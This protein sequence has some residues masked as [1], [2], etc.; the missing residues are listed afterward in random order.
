[1][2][3]L[4][5]R[6]RSAASVRCRIA[7]TSRTAK[8]ERFFDRGAHPP[9]PMLPYQTQHLDHL[10]CAALLAVPTD[11]FG[12]QAIVTLW[13]EPT[14]PPRRQRLRSDQ[15][16]RL[17][18][19]H[20]EIA[21]EIE[22]LLMAFV[23][24]LVAGEAAAFVPDLDA[25]RMESD[26]DRPADLD[27]SR[28]QVGSH[29]DAA[30]PIDP[31]ERDIGQVEAVLGERQQ[32]RAFFDHQRAHRPA[33]PSDLTSFVGAAGGQQLCVEIFEIARFRHRHPVVAP[34][35]AGLAL[36]AALFVRLVR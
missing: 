36:D 12:Q 30:Q 29:S 26:L 6:T 31:W 1:M 25:T 2:M 20:V 17:T 13:P 9:M 22:H 27:R 10:A 23:T 19:Q 33:L 4:R 15:R 3:V 8:R 16:S 32:M 21:C 28:I 7:A 34:E 5:A 35:V 18:L 24:A 11:Q 14:L